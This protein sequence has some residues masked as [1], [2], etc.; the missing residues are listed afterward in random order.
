MTIEKRTAKLLGGYETTIYP[1]ALGEMWAIATNKGS[2]IKV[3]SPHDEPWYVIIAAQEARD[4]AAALLEI[5]GE[6]DGASRFPPDEPARNRKG[7][8]GTADGSVQHETNP[9]IRGDGGEA[10]QGQA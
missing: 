8:Q 10:P 6:I 2:A 7:E 1:T 5:A 3:L 9:S 4:A